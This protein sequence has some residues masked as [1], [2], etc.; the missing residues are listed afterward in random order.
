MTNLSSKRPSSVYAIKCGDFIK[1]GFGGR[2][3]ER[4]AAMSLTCPY[5]MELMASREYPDA[6]TAY[7]AEREV[8]LA[9]ASQRH[10]G[11]WFKMTPVDPIACLKSLH[12]AWASANGRNQV[13]VDID[14]PERAPDV[15]FDLEEQI[16]LIMAQ[17]DEVA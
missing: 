13:L 1:I 7:V 17:D 12:A 14:E 11:E 2:P 15:P 10:W 9:L 8:H 4:L 6:K 5:P 3:R 16:R